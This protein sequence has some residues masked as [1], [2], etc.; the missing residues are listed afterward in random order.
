L[1]GFGLLGRDGQ[2][3]RAAVVLFIKRELVLPEFSQCQLRLARFRGVDKSE[4]LDSKQLH[5]NAFDL[6]QAAQRFLVENLPVAGRVRAGLFEREDDP[7]YPP[8][9]LREALANAFCHRDYAIGG[10]SVGIAIFDDRVEITSSGSLHFDLTVE[11]LLKPHESLPWNPLIARVFYLRGVVEQWGRGI[12]KIVELMELAGLPVPDIE[13][14][15]ST[16]T[17][18]FRPGRYVAPTRVPHDLSERQ[19]VILEILSGGERLLPSEVHSRLP[20]SV[21]GSNNDPRE[22]RRTRESLVELRSMGL[23]SQTGRGVGSRWFL[24]PR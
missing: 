7:L 6:L 21:G 15:S 17:V 10:G 13:A 11:A 9:A 1:R 14:S 23:V 18:R 12:Q 2:V 22:L 3:L 16:V 8:A 20:A 4:F 5:G 24:S 19:R